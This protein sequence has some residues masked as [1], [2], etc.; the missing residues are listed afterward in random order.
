MNLVK[1][2]SFAGRISQMRPVAGL[3]STILVCFCLVGCSDEATMPS[4]GQLMEFE[5]AGP[6]RPSVDMNRLVRAKIGGGPYRVVNGD[7]L[8]L[9][10]PAILLAVTHEQA[11]AA[12]KATPYICR[13]GESGTVSLPLVGEI[14][15]ATKTL[16]QIESAVIEAYYPA[17]SATR[18]SVFA[19]VTEYRTAKISITGA[20]NKPGIYALSSDQMSLVALLMEAGGI[21][22]EGAAVIRI[23]HADRGLVSENQHA[24]TDFEVSVEKV[25]EPQRIPLLTPTQYPPDN[26]IKVDLAFEQSSPSSTTGELKVTH[27]QTLLLAERLDVTNKEDRLLLLWKLKQAEPSV[28]IPYADRKLC[29]LAEQLKQA[30]LTEN[31]DSRIPENRPGAG[32]TPGDGLAGRKVVRSNLASGGPLPSGMNGHDG[33]WHEANHQTLSYEDA[34]GQ[35]RV[36]DKTIHAVTGFYA[37]ASGR[38]FAADA[39]AHSGRTSAYAGATPQNGRITDIA[40]AEKPQEF[41]LPIKGLNIPFA[42]VALHDG[43][44]VVVERLAE[45]LFSVMGLVNRAGNFPYPPDVQFNLMQALAFAGGLNEAASPRYATIYRLKPDGTIVHVI[46]Q[47]ATI[48]G[49]SWPQEAFNIHIKPGDVVIV[50][51]TPRTESKLFLDRIFHVNFGA[52]VPVWR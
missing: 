32:S 33:L 4:A 44:T 45:P 24:G 41:V 13:V 19:R 2:G 16:A 26:S 46:F 23:I 11:A 36:D 5:N 7:V 35:N 29:S 12:D 50:E 9:T 14:K 37:D 1:C 25:K 6:L 30:V 48:R 27:G 40:V 34:R 47:V 21:T 8:E 31:K 20:V 49:G 17:Y 3:F 22:D 52:Y 18:P 38:D 28:S 10:M 43:D 42:D 39:T 51:H 15:V